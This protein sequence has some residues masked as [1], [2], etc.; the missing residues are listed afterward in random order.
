MT[1]GV[2]HGQL[3]PCPGSRNCVSSQTSNKRHAIKPFRYQGTL[4][5]AR[6]RLVDII[7]AVPRSKLVTVQDDYVHAEFRSRLFG[8][9]DD[10]E[11]SFDE[12]QKTIHLRSASR[13]GSYDFGMNRKR[14]ERVRSQFNNLENVSLKSGRSEK[15]TSSRD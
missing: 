4:A 6:R 5:E 3:S 7:K 12:G 15:D 13:T 2:V 9:V 11:F 10:A 8:F 1:L 14:M